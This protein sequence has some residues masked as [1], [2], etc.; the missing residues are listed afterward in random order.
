MKENS[1][2]QDT[3][4]ITNRESDIQIFKDVLSNFIGTLSGSMFIYGMGY[5]L[6]DQ[7]GLAMSFGIDM[8]ITPII[9]LL[10]LIPVGNLTDRLPHKKF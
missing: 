6:L 4:S 8:L 3:Q 9:G 10:F 7:T 5:M 1:K 2:N